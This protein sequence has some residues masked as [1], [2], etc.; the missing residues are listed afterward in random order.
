[1]LQ[2]TKDCAGITLARRQ[3]DSGNCS[4]RIFS[5]RSFLARAL[6]YALLVSALI[7]FALPVWHA[8][9][10]TWPVP[11]SELL[12]SLGFHSTYMAG[13]EKSY[14]HSGLDIPASA[15]MQISSPVAGT[16]CYVG[17]VPSGDSRVGMSGGA[18]GETMCAVSVEMADG[19]RVTLMPV[20][21]V[22]V[23][24]GQHVAE[25]EALGT[26]AASGDA[27]SAATHLHMGLKKGRTYYDP[28]TLFGV[29]GVGSAAP[30]NTSSDSS[31]NQRE[32]NE[33]ASET[34]QDASVAQGEG[35]SIGEAS[36]AAQSL[37]DDL[38]SDVRSS[39]SAPESQ[40]EL[41]K[42]S[43]GA[44]SWEPQEQSQGTP[45]RDVF[46]L[47]NLVS[48]CKSQL[49]DLAQGLETV[50][51]SSGIPITALCLCVLVLLAAVSAVVAYAFRSLVV[52]HVATLWKQAK[53]VLLPNNGGVSMSKLFPASG[54]AFFAR[55]R[56]A[57]RR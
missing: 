41:G 9:A 24:Q 15:G 21:E 38:V 2:T 55:S 5:S 29:A 34:E 48:A 8:Q 4:F 47:G 31:S 27:S 26:L 51:Q 57:R 36:P 16:A 44:V 32:E 6:G 50:S 18:D 46:G 54:S 19:R 52:P 25:G 56:L 35:V 20:A 11:S 13:N 12:S 17:D 22:Y 37:A 28:M 39:S 30:S 7:L 45:L 10:A 40:G 1:M 53:N 23:Q 42:I 14:V 49:A 33:T 43:S 3:Q